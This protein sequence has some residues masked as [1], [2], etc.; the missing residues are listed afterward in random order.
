[1]ECP[2]CKVINIEGY[3]CRNCG[4]DIT[5]Y[6]KSTR[7]SNLLYNQ[8]LEKAEKSELTAAINV[9]TQSIEF[10]KNNVVARN[11]LGL[12]YYEIGQIGDSI[13]QWIIST[14]MVKINN[15][16]ML[17]MKNI[18]NNPD[19]L[20]GKNDAVI[21]YNKSLEYMENKD[22]AKAIE[23]LKKATEINPK[24]LSALNLLTF[25]YLIEGNKDEALTL[26]SR[27]LKLDKSNKV[28]SK[29]Y[30][31]IT[32]KPYRPA[33]DIPRP[34][35]VQTTVIAPPPASVES[36]TKKYSFITIAHAMSFIA[37]GIITIAALFFFII[38]GLIGDRDNEI[39]ALTLERNQLS[40]TLN[41]ERESNE[42]ALSELREENQELRAQVTGIE[43]ENRTI[44][45]TALIEEA[46][47]L[48]ATGNPRDAA[49]NLY[50]IDFNLVSVE[51]IE[52]VQNL[53]LTTFSAAAYEY[54]GL[55]FQNYNQGN[56]EIAIGYFQNSLRFAEF[57]LEESGFF[58]DDAAY[59]LGRIWQIQ[60]NYEWARNSFLRVIEN[61][62]GSSVYNQA[63]QRLQEVELA[64]ALAALEQLPTE[65][66]EENG[67]A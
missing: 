15:Q 38:P 18:Q 61:Y 63:M 17:Y 58:I 30:I 27:V 42:T 45:Q 9:L 3:L 8:G 14:N 33:I 34:K 10:N 31:V 29:Y 28:A 16:A 2:N 20:Y 48:I 37:G 12:I 23:E 51:D 62:P 49:N 19:D 5:V 64:I 7:I 47:M 22:T 46:R 41:T 35:P 67:D 21:H 25:V 55:G 24:F 43:L 44:A 50:N 66:F 59:F 53:M 11:L 36:E 32:G 13:K 52:D 4:I 39:S 60:G 65:E 6:T 56:F 1:M 54:Y 57:N 26:I 40:T